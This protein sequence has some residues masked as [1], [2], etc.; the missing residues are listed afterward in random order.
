MDEKKLTPWF[1]PHIKPVREGFY[2][3]TALQC[4][5]DPPICYWDGRQWWRE[6][7]ECLAYFQEQR[8]WRGLTYEAL[9]DE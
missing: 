1:P 6:D 4:Y 8:E 9:T 5:D 7:R 2:H 3:A